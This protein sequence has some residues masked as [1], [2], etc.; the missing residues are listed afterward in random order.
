M[1]YERVVTG[2]SL[3]P[4]ITSINNYVISFIYSLFFWLGFSD[5]VLVSL[6]VNV[7]VISIAYA[8][9]ELLCFQVTK[10]FLP[11]LYWLGLLSALQFSI[12]IN[13]DSF[14]VLFYVVL[15]S[16]LMFRKRIDLCLLLILCPIRLQFLLVFVFSVFIASSIN[17]QDRKIRVI[18]KVGVLYVLCSIV[19]M[20]LE[21][22]E[23]LLAHSRYAEGGVA[24]WISN[25]NN[26]FYIGSLLLNVLKPIQYVYDLFRSASVDH[27]VLGWGVYFSR[28][29]L[30]FLI[31]I[32][33]LYFFIAVYLPWVVIRKRE[34]FIAS[35]VICSFFLVYSIS[36]VVNYRYLLNISPVLILFF[37]MKKFRQVRVRLIAPA[38]STAN[39][40]SLAV[41]R[42]SH[43]D[44]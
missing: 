26:Q 6:F 29:Y 35:V 1:F 37:A 18:A 14:G 42:N 34:M 3:I 27:S 21:S 30:F 25:L 4:D 44:E 19:A 39:R 41:E 11:L 38:L 20:Y 8:R 17:S 13:K 43:L 9:S 5:L 15:V 24:Q 23:A 2:F 10:R 7:I 28:L 36:P 16:F 33:S 22:N 32:F 40:P 12:L 31:M